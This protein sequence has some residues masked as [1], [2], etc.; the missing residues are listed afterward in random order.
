M[1]LNP[2]EQLGVERDADS[3]TIKKAYRRKARACHPDRNP[4]DPHATTKFQLLQEAFEILSDPVRRKKFD[5]TGDTERDRI[6]ERALA[7]VAGTLLQV[8]K[9]ADLQGALEHPQFQVIQALH[10][11]LDQMRSGAQKRLRDCE[12]VKRS[13]EK[14]LGRFK[15]KGDG[16]N[17]IRDL[18]Q[19]QIDSAAHQAK[20]H[21]A[22]VEEIGA[23]LNVLDAYEDLPPEDLFTRMQLRIGQ[24]GVLADIASVT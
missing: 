13:L 4:D 15:F 5:E 11:A 8:L 22:D 12:R 3:A 1:A 2:Y 20:K 17:V 21:A 18:M 10:E 14:Q 9:Q 24:H 6:E 16:P 19:D 7:L 23:A